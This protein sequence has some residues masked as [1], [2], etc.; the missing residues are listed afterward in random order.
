MEN[1]RLV[2]QFVREELRSKGFASAQIE[3]Q[4]TTNT[5]ISKGLAHASK[6]GS[7]NKGFPEFIIQ[8][9][10][11]RDTVLIIEC[12]A[13]KKWHCSTSNMEP[14]NYAVDGVL[15]YAKHLAKYKQ[16]VYAVAV[17]GVHRPIISTFLVEYDELG[18][19]SICDLN[20]DRIE[21]P[22]FYIGF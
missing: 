1:E 22:F 4:N 5:F 7:G 16:Y 12:K 18:D 10:G 15:H 3:E 13:S 17:S 6:N 8:F 21:G 20:V 19:L 9:P 11:R 14:V 2:E